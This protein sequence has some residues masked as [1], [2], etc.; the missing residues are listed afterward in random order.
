MRTRLFKSGDSRAVRIPDEL[1]FELAAEE[2]DIERVG[3]D[4]IIRPIQPSIRQPLTHVVEKFKAFSPGLADEIRGIGDRCATLPVLDART[5]DEIL[6]YDE[7][8]L[9]RR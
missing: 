5:P 6:D 7:Q 2:V 4:L 8:G 1:G 3:D 9:P